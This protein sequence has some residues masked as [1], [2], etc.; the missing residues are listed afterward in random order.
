MKI[1]LIDSDLLM[2]RKNS[3]PNL[4][5][6][7]ISGYHKAKGNTAELILDYSQ[8]SSEG[9]FIPIKH[10]DKIYLSKVFTDTT[11]PEWI[12]KL[13][14]L[15]YGGTGFFFDKAPPLPNDMEHHFPDYDL[16]NRWVSITLS[17]GNKASRLKISRDYSLGYL[18][19]GCIRQ[20]DFCVNRNK[21]K[22]ILHSPL[23]E[24][25]NESKPF[26][27]LLDDNILACPDWE[28]LLK[29]LMETGKP[30]RF[31][32]GIDIRLLTDKSAEM[33]SRS[34]YDHK[35]YFAFDNYNEKEI[36]VKKLRLWRKYADNTESKVYVLVG[37]DRANRYDKNFGLSDVASAF[38][39]IKIITDFGCLPFVMRF[40]KVKESPFQKL[41]SMIANWCNSSGFIYKKSF[42]QYVYYKKC[43]IDYFDGFE[44]E[45]PKIAQKYFDWKR[46]GADG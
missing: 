45:N 38:E 13:P 18:S 40:E 2:R 32:Q 5:L 4:A 24:F 3:F 27:C 21:R 28:R 26:I 36:I 7:K 43:N 6:M 31:T 20:C 12:L 37:Y 10:Y 19:K 23:K 22:S 33:L 8:L 16:Y 46:K 9:M 34:N 11:V 25:Y 41:Y 15:T 39:R 44:K 1:G 14:N 35:I 29:E 17:E 30:F 42:R